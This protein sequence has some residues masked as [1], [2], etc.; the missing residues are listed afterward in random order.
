M[1]KETQDSS[2]KTQENGFER[3][4]TDKKTGKTGKM[5]KITQLI[6]F[7]YTKYNEYDICYEKEG[8]G[9]NFTL[10]EITTSDAKILPECR[11]AH[12][13]A[14]IELDRVLKIHYEMENLLK[15]IQPNQPKEIAD[16]IT[17]LLNVK[18]TEK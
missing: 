18:G 15:A 1:S 5:E 16:K 13:L 6:G 11:E 2:R 10:A 7:Y 17:E 3:M 4:G 8:S 9:C 14:I 12:R